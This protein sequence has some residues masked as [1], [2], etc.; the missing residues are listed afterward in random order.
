MTARPAAELPTSEG[1]SAYEP[2]MD[3][4]RCAAYR[5]PHGKVTLQ[6]RQQ[7]PLTRYF[8]EVV[9][10]LQEQLTGGVVLDG[11]LV[12]CTDGRL[13]F[14]ALQRRLHTGRARRLAAEAPACLVVFDILAVGV[15]DLRGLPYVQRRSL[16]SDLLAAVTPPLALMPLTTRRRPK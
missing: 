13:D 12:V 15:D 7:R 5:Q 9:A 14:A 16:V 8:P 2:K 3:G 10:A 6:S 11:E 1:R 4:F